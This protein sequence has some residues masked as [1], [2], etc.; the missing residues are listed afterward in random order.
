M[1]IPKEQKKQMQSMILMNPIM[2]LFICL[3]VSGSVTL[4]WAAGNFFSVIQQLIVTFIIMPKV[5]KEVDEEL[6]REPMTQVVT[7]E[8]VAELINNQAANP[9]QSEQTRELH[10]NLRN[11]NKGKQQKRP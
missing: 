2:T 11:R 3:S 4:Y 10:E 8:K 6:K 7:K 9:A 5:K 1:G